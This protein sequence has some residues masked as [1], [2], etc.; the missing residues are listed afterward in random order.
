VNLSVTE[1][2]A[3][4]GVL[5]SVG[6]QIAT[7]GSHRARLEARER[8]AASSGKRLED[9]NLRVTVLEHES[10]ITRRPSVVVPLNESSDE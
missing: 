5:I 4:G 9:L 6:I 7:I 10:G 8:G 3:L 2:F 1:L